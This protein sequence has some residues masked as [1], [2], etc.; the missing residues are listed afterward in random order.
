MGLSHFIFCTRLLSVTPILSSLDASSFYYSLD[1]SPSLLYV[2]I[3]TYFY[4]YPSLQKMVWG[5]P[6]KLTYVIFSSKVSFFAPPPSAL[7]YSFSVSP[8]PYS[9][10]FLFLFLCPSCSSWAPPKKSIEGT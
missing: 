7:V 5:N 6:M 2:L 8:Y 1:L 4:S 3:I 9:T 10:F